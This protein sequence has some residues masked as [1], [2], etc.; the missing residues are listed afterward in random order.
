MSTFD[1]LFGTANPG[2]PA[3]LGSVSTPI[4]D[5]ALRPLRRSDGQLWRAA[6]TRDQSLIQRWDPSSVLTWQQRHTAG[7]WSIHRRMLTRGA[8][9]G[10]AL[11]FAIIVDG[12]FCGQV[13]VGGIARGPLHSGWIGYWVDSEFAGHGV[14]TAATA[15]AAA[16]AFG[17][18]GLH[19][20]EATVAPANVASQKVLAHL[21]FRQEGLLQRYLDI[22]G[23][24]MDHQLWAMTAEEVP[25]GLD[26]LLQQW[27]R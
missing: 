15:L 16:H 13:T 11:P 5:V 3:H 22:D 18:G 26:S 2:W 25:Q 10:S 24:W 17:A 27:R 12:H 1:R 7:Q 8:R 21:G 19:R 4:G 20:L 23:A 14:A 6:R 9:L